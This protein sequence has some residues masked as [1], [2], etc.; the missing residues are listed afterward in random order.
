MV[1]VRLKIRQFGTCAALQLPLGIPAC[2]CVVV[3]QL[4]PSLLANHC[5]SKLYI[6][7]LKMGRPVLAP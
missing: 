1:N 2:S 4:I 3:V 6:S 5:P 7:E